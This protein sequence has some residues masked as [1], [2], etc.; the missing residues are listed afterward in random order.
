MSTGFIEEFFSTL[1]SVKYLGHAKQQ[2]AIWRQMFILS[3]LLEC[4]AE[5]TQFY[6]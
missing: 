1:K 3:I 2:V 5:D 6:C 4:K